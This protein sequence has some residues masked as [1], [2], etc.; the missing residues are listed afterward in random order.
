VGFRAF[1]PDGTEKWVFR[2]DKGFAEEARPLVG[3]DGTIYPRGANIYAITPE[4]NMI[5]Q[6]NL[7]APF[8]TVVASP[9]G[10]VIYSVHSLILYAI[11]AA[12]GD[13]LWSV[14]TGI[15]EFE[16]GP[17]V[18]NQGNI[19]Y[20]GCEPDRKEYIY[21][22]SPEGV[23]RWKFYLTD[24]VSI[25]VSSICIDNNGYIYIA[26][27]GIGITALDY[28][29][30]FRWR[31]QKY[32][33]SSWPIICDSENR[34][35]IGNWEAPEFWC[36]HYDGSL[37]AEFVIPDFGPVYYFAIGMNGVMYIGGSSHSVVAFE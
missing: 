21:S 36:H 27:Y 35:Y 6:Q 33:Y 28:E 9:D 25:N 26:W 16:Y 2:E 12:T 18:D 23:E 13:I 15:D 4:G 34:L 37:I 30:Q 29:G 3:I 8:G 31:L 5:W 7:G 17:A 1:N 10:S 11:D 22:L 20:V 32:N 24:M 19:Y 14:D